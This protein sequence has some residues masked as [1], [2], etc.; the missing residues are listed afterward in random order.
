MDADFRILLNDTCILLFWNQ[1]SKTSRDCCHIATR[2]VFYA[3]GYHLWNSTWHAIKIRIGIAF[4]LS[5]NVHRIVWRRNSRAIIHNYVILV[6]LKYLDLYLITYVEFLYCS[7]DNN[8]QTW[9]DMDKLNYPVF[10]HNNPNIVFDDM[11]VHKR[12]LIAI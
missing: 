11:N 9:E 10:W 12:Y 3:T 6:N 7:Y 5:C 4:T 2:I 1:I 8:I